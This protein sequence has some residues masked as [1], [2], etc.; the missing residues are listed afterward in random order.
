MKIRFPGQYYDSETGLHYN[1]HRYYDPDTGRY[2]TSDPIGLEG[3]IN[4]YPY[5]LNDPVNKIDPDGRLVITIPAIVLYG[6]FA[7]ATT[8]YGTKAINDTQKYLESRRWD[9][10]ED[11]NIY[12]EEKRKLKEANKYRPPNDEDPDK[13]PPPVIR[14]TPEQQIKREPW[15]SRIWRILTSQYSE[16]C[17]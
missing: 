9:N 6:A 7:V 10:H 2:L 16:P 14:P 4:L 17:P 15:L 5:V 1:W 8:Y 13:N 11:P 12:N 3:G